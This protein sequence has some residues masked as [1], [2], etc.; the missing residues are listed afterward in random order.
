MVGRDL[1]VPYSAPL[2]LIFYS[3]CNKTDQDIRFN[4]YMKATE[5]SLTYH[6]VRL[7][8]FIIF[9]HTVP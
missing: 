3:N 9:A 6:T 1:I 8:H 5:D 4:V 7:A 2:L